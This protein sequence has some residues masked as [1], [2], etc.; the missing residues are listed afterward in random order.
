M[1]PVGK[2]EAPALWAITLGPLVTFLGYTIGALLWPGYDGMVHTISDL[3]AN[4]SPVQ[5]FISAVFLF[6][7]L[8]DVVVSHYSK[9]LATPGRIVILLSAFT[10]V[11]LTVFTTPSQIGHSIPHRI[12]AIASFALLAIWPALSM[13]KGT[14]GPPLLRPK[15]AIIETLILVATCIWFISLWGSHNHSITG[16][17]ERIGVAVEGIVPM[18][19]L[20][21][22]WLWQREQTK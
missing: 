8:C 7:A 22:S 6:G 18:V 19:V 16:L 5:L 13:R 21:H 3:A 1:K 15:A 20:W 2:I 4:D 11:G 10:T 14:N 12:F 17:G 9:A